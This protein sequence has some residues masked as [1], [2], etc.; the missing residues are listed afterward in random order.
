MKEQRKLA[1]IMFTDIV[2]YSAL[3]SKDEN[4]ALQILNRNRE[5]QKA[6]L[7]R[8][9]GEFIKEIGDG[10]LS[11]FQ[12][13]WDAVSCAMELQSTLHE[14]AYFQLRIGIHMGDV[15]V[16]EK[17]I[18][19]DGV[20]I[21]SRI[22][23][24]CEPGGI[25]ISETVYNDIRNKTAISVECIGERQ[26]KNIDQPVRIYS[27]SAD[28]IRQWK[29][30]TPE[31]DQG[32]RILWRSWYKM[33]RIGPV[34]K[35]TLLA[36]GSII[37]L[38]VGFFILRPYILHAIPDSGSVPIAVIS[39]ENQTGDTSFNYLQKAIPNLLI[40]NLEQSKL[41][42]VLTWE[43]M[44]DVMRQLGKRDAEIIDADL[45][46]EICSNE[47]C[48][49]IVIGSFVRAGDVFATD[50]K[51]L[52]VES[53]KI[54]NSVSS[55]GN[56]VG[57]II[58]TQIDELSK[59]ISRSVG[60]SARKVETARMRI[61]DVTTHSLEAYNY[62][63]KGREAGDKLYWNEARQYF[64]KAV[65]IDPGFAMAYLYLSRTYGQL[66]LGNIQKRDEALEKAYR[67]SRRATENEQLA[68][69][70]DYAGIIEQ[71]SQ[72]QRDLLLELA[73]KAPRDKRVFYSLGQWYRDNNSPAKAI[74]AFKKT[75]EL[76]PSFGEADNQLAYLYFNKGEYETALEYLRIYSSLNPGDANPFD[77]MGD[78]LWKMG[79]LDEAIE[80]YGKALEIKSNF[81]PSAA[82]TAYIFAMKEDYG[83]TD[84]WVKKTLDAAWSESIK[85][86]IY[87]FV[88]FL[89]YF[90]GKL[91]LAMPRI[92]KSEAIAAEYKNDLYQMGSDYLRAY[93]YYDLGE[94]KKAQDHYSSYQKAALTEPTIDRDDDLLVYYFFKGLVHLKLNQ[95][96][97]SRNCTERIKFLSKDLQGDYYYNYLIREIQIASAQL[98]GDLDNITPE[99]EQPVPN[100]VS[101]Y[102]FIYNL[103]FKRNS[104]AEAYHHFGQLDKA[105]TGYEHMI[106]PNPASNERYIVNPRYHYYLGILYQE[107]GMKEQSVAQYRKFLD[108]WQDADPIFKE[109]DD[110][111]K[112]LAQL[113][114]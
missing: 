79:K 8:H 35:M 54:M 1:A 57:S 94:Y 6:A 86:N 56:N 71:D 67:S 2:G 92:D 51:V 11:I 16:S 114:K 105:I 14:T 39:F 98:P 45:G 38:F 43:R 64:E 87:W 40:T 82:K 12:S 33:D 106:A 99:V 81:W 78:L 88:A 4:V 65:R 15:V 69:R 19:G 80:Q 97:S 18:F 111:R 59:S 55:K 103:P 52:D 53:K 36:M 104:L 107:K 29:E 48:R 3:M 93:I 100:F 21:A 37:L 50:A 10:T 22:Q 60:F 26:L 66:Q 61:R 108:L 73:E 113:L 112:R 101:P 47:G 49:F 58:E 96:D 72:K 30:M 63:L 91:N 46:F 85:A 7:S 13:S 75:V 28:C 27:I 34:I 42:Q 17:D 83:M 23:A 74:D 76:D 110:A 62:F 44:Q 41:F 90:Y 70:A 84:Q 5:L 25:L 24:L 9:H 77:S 102:V 95:P 109:P 31:K 32:G 20:N 68:I 89:D